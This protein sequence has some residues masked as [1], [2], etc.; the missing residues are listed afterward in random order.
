MAAARA[1]SFVSLGDNTEVRGEFRL[2]EAGEDLAHAEA[3]RSLWFSPDGRQLVSAGD[4]FTIRIWDAVTGR[5]QQALRGHG[6]SVV[7][8]QFGPRDAD[9]VI[10]AGKDRQIKTWRLSTYAEEVAFDGDAATSAQGSPEVRAH[11]DEVLSALRRQR[12]SHRHHQSRPDREA[13]ERE[14]YER[15]HVA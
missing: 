14:P 15:P 2:V 7:A 12:H 9:L 11:R 6:Q 3:I 5:E 8:A 10:S 1:A 13:V 4:D